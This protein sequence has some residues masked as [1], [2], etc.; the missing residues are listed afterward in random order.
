MGKFKWKEL[1]IPYTLANTDPPD[2]ELVEKAVEVF[3]AA[4]LVAV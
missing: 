1:G 2:Q 3:K 4:G